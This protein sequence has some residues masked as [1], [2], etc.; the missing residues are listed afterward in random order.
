MN[1]VLKDQLGKKISVYSNSPGMERQDVGILEDYNETWIKV[2]K[3]ESEIIY[4][5][6][7]QVRMIKPFHQ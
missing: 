2:R 3:S 1:N 6:V 7:H 5:S 4:F